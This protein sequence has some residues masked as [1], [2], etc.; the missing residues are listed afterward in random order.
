MSGAVSEGGFSNPPWPSGAVS[1]GGFSN[2]PWPDGLENPSSSGEKC[3]LACLS[4]R[5]LLRRSDGCC[6]TGARCS[7]PIQKILGVIQKTAGMTGRRQIGS[8]RRRLLLLQGGGLLLKLLNGIVEVYLRTD[9]AVII[10]SRTVPLAEQI[11]RGTDGRPGGWVESGTLSHNVL[12]AVHHHQTSYQVP[13]LHGHF[14]FWFKPKHV[15]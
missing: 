6:S 7:A 13:V 3:R 12:H 2:P 11:Q 10:E 15:A 14:H 8:R 1:E 9:Q 4:R 5:R